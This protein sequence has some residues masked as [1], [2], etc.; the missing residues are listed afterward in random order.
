M[1]ILYK[2]LIE[3]IYEK[4]KKFYK[5]NLV[6]FVIFGSVA[7]GTTNPYSDID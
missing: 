4:V 3:N 6:S 5:D 1:K 2:D 7:R